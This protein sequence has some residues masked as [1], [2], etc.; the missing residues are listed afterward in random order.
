MDRQLLKKS[1]CLLCV[2][3]V[4]CI[5]DSKYYIR[6]IFLSFINILCSGYIL[7]PFS[8]IYVLASKKIAFF[9]SVQVLR[10]FTHY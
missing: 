5:Y 1:K 6:F 10:P 2:T 3:E 4:A 9:I 8:G 7:T